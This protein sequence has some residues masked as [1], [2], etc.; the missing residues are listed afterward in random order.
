M[1]SASFAVISCENRNSSAA[2]EV[3]SLLFGTELSKTIADESSRLTALEQI[4]L[5]AVDVQDHKLSSL[6]LS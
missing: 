4:C 5:D 1:F 3:P 6:L 2:M